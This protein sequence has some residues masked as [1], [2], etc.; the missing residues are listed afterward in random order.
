MKMRTKRLA[1]LNKVI[2]WLAALLFVTAP[3]IATPHSPTLNPDA[4]L[5]IRVERILGHTPGTALV[6]DMRAQRVLAVTD[7]TVAFSQ[8]FA[9]GSLMKLASALALLQNH[10][11]AIADTVTCTNHLRL[12]GRDFT[13][14]VDGGH[15]TVNLRQAIAKSCSI[16]FYTMGQRVTSA[17]LRLAARQLGLGAP[18]PFAA[19]VSAHVGM[20]ASQR[21]RTLM[22]VGESAV[23]ITPWDAVVMVSRIR[24]ASMARH[25]ALDGAQARFLLDSMRDGVADGT[26]RPAAVPGIDVRGKTGTATVAPAT[27]EAPARTRGWFAGTAG[28]LAFAVFLRHGTGHDAAA[29]AGRILRACREL[30]QL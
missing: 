6:Y 8:R 3:A 2:P 21:E 26:G 7:A 9:P 5:Q 25:G 18:S 30:K 4:A 27:A 24:A 13:C 20:P 14:G 12:A 19:G 1:H 10:A 15:G 16:Y 17:Q 28:H 11:V 23:Q 22:L 29:L